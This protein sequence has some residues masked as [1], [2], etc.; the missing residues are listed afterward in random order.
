MLK[1]LKFAKV[2]LLY[3]KGSKSDSGNHRHVSVLGIMSKVLERVCYDQ[4]YEYIQCKDLLYD[5]QSGFRKSYSTDSCLL[6]LTDYIKDD[7]DQ[8]KFCGCDF[9][10]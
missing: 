9:Q 10:N 2:I 8:G 4:V 6:N 5:L 7:I 3:K 1:D